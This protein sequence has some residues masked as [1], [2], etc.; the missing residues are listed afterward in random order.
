MLLRLLLLAIPATLA[1]YW[2][3]G[4]RTTLLFFAAW[5]R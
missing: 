4:D 5:S 2:L 3:D 1:V